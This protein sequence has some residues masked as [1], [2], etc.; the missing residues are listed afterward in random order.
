MKQ[1]DEVW[2]EGKLELV[3]FLVNPARFGTRPPVSGR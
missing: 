3:P 2:N 1:W